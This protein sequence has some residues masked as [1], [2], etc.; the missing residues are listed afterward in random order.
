LEEELEETKGGN[1]NR[2]VEEG[3]ITQWPIEEGKRDIIVV[4]R[5]FMIDT[6]LLYNLRQI[7]LLVSYAYR[8]P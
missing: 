1:Q 8:C 4:I 5:N 2:D 3:Q 6:I 7:T